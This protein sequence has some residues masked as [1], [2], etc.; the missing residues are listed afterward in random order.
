MLGTSPVHKLYAEAVGD[1]M[2]DLTGDEFIRR[3]SALPLLHDPGTEWH[4]GFGFDLLGLIVESLVGTPLRAYLATH[5]FEPLGMLDTTFGGPGEDVER[6]AVPF[7]L[8]P[9][10]GAPQALPDLTRARFDSGGAGLV[11]SA[12]DYLRFVQMLL[13][14]G[15]AGPGRLL[16]RKTVQYMLSD[17]LDPT[18]DTRQLEKPG[19]NCGHGFGLGLAVRRRSGG[20]STAGSIGEATWP[21]AA[22]T[23]WWVDP[24]EDIGVVFMAHTPS[25]IQARYQQQIKALVTQALG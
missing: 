13:T 12:G 8:D 21:G 9:E 14:G 3:L 7:P 10:T 17:Q 22:G 11:S 16:G 15:N 4:Y 23:T 24:R 19:W 1:G 20:A 18:T 6:Y 25:R 2:T 5:V